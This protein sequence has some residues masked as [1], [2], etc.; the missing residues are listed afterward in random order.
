MFFKE[1][2]TSGKIFIYLFI[3]LIDWLID[4]LLYLF[5]S[6]FPSQI[7]V[8]VTALT[9]RPQSIYVY[10]YIYKIMYHKR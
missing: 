9:F 10:I 8:R 7:L 4:Y 3:Y 5:P 2:W 1:Y 6:L